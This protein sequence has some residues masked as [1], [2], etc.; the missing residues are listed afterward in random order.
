MPDPS[1][2]SSITYYGN[3]ETEK[4][5][6]ETETR[7]H[8]LDYVITYMKKASNVYS[9]I[10][11]VDGAGEKAI[12]I[13]NQLILD[14]QRLLQSSE[15][16][17]PALQLVENQLKEQRK[18]LIESVESVRQNIQI[19]LDALYKKDIA[20]SKQVDKLP[21]QEREFIEMKRQQRIKETMY[22]FLMQKIQEK[23]LL[24]HLMNLQEE[25]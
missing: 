22:L 19:S 8:M 10:P 21:T 3:K 5:I 4:L 20:L 17:N 15:S 24:I 2:Y 11:I 1:A 16:N 12:M 9:A 6:L 14:R 7:M 18:I 13:Y 25:L 23:E